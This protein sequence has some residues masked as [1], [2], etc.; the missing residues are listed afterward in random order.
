MPARAPVEPVLVEH[1]SSE[2]EQIERLKRWWRDNGKA[3][4]LGLVVGIG[5]LA[6][7]RYWEGAQ[8][9]RAEGASITYELVLQLLEDGRLDDVEKTGQTLLEKYPDTPYARMTALLLAKIAVDRTDFD[10]ARD[11]LLPLADGDG[12]IADVARVRLARLALGA[13]DP[14]GAAAHLARVAPLAA[15]DRYAELRGDVLATQGDAA[16]AREQYTRA[17]E[18][19]ERL[20]L[21]TSIIELKLER[22]AGT[23]VDNG[24]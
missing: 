10:A 19:A 11:L 17:L 21:D 24:S 7:Y 1:Y 20:G 5:G 14:A 16:A 23:A 15:G 3:L 22:L 2:Q 6:G 4:I 8:T 9:A 13:D 18:Q 12:E